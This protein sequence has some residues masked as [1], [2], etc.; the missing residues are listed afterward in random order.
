VRLA[1]AL[2]ANRELREAEQ[3]LRA[4]M[5][6]VRAASFTLPA[7][8]VSE[9]QSAL[10]ICLAAQGEGREAKSLLEASQA[11]VRSDSHPIFRKLSA[12]RLGKLE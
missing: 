6:E 12:A 3:I 10:G 5:K 8:Q 1:E 7:W 9:I 2:T 11:G 4:A